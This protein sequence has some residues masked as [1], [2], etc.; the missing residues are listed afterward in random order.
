MMHKE[1]ICAPLPLYDLIKDG[2][3]N[4]ELQGC[5]ILTLLSD[6][7]RLWKNHGYINAL[8][9]HFCLSLN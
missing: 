9:K 4:S 7:L 1:D 2:M 5:I 3:T 6:L 8:G